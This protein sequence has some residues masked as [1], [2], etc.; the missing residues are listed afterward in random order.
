MSGVAVLG[1][2]NLDL[3]VRAE[4]LPGPGETIS[5]RSF[6]TVPGGK[7]LNQA[8]AARRAGAG[9]ALLAAI[10]DDGAG[11]ELA[12]CIA[13]EGIDA[14][15]LVR[16]PGASGTAHIT[17]QD[18]GENSIVVVP[19]ANGL[20]QPLDDRRR[21]AIAAARLLLMQLE[22]PQPMLAEAARFARQAGVITVLT[23]APVQE[24]DPALLA[25]TEV[26]VPNQ[27]EAMQLAGLDDPEAAALALSPGR[28]VLVTLG[29]EGVLAV[30]DGSVLARVPGRSVAAIDTTAAGDTF[31]G[32][33]AARLAE[34]T[35]IEPALEW[36]TAAAAI[37][38]T[39]AG[40]T[41]SMPRR[42]EVEALLAV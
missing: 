28:T 15:C 30:R 41:S 33:L 19:G 40:A 11:R 20:L 39:R 13:A 32:A 9:V 34:G 35:L 42:D 4:R 6:A 14:E 37:S 24:L 8:V 29:A 7:G 26:L 17:V 31:V 27:H 1:S 23:P 21:A 12:D 38:V 16:A 22:V 18:S 10:G 5:G 3:V 2:A 25:A 36:A